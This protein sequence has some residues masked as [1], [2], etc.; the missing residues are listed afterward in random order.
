ML[1]VRDFCLVVRTVSNMK[2]PHCS[3][4]RTKEIFDLYFGAIQIIRDTLRG[5]V[6][7]IVTK[8]HRGRGRGVNQKCHMSFFRPFLN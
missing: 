7:D 3:D 8:C 4:P 5:E 6:R 2:I 1:L